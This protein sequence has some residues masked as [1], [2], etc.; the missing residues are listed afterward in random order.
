MASDSLKIELDV[1]T[2]QAVQGLAAV[3]R[4]L[5]SAED[6]AGEA[7]SAFGRFTAGMRAGSDTAERYYANVAR[8]A[9]VLAGLTRSVIDGTAAHERNERA[10]RTLG[11]AYSEV[12]RQTQGAF[13]AAEAMR[14]QQSLVQ[15]GLQLSGEELGRVTRAAREYALA[16]GTEATA[17]LE[18]LT[19]ALRGGE[20]EG[21][22]AFGITLDATTTRSQSFRAALTQLETQQ[23]G[24]APTAQTM[25]EANADLSRAWDRL[26]NSLASNVAQWTN[27]RERMSAVSELMGDLQENGLQNYLT[28]NTAAARDNRRSSE[29]A[30]ARLGRT[31]GWNNSLR[32]AIG[33]IGGEDLEFARASLDFPAARMTELTRRLDSATTIEELRAIAN[34]SRGARDTGTAA[35]VQAAANVAST[36]AMAQASR[37]KAN[38]RTNAPTAP[39]HGSAATHEPSKADLEAAFARQLVVA[40]EDATDAKDAAMAAFIRQQAEAMDTATE[41][42]RFSSQNTAAQNEMDLAAALAE[43][44][45]LKA[46]EQGV[47]DGNATARARRENPAVT[48]REAFLPA[49]METQTAAERMA[50]G[51][52]GA[53]Q[54][55]VGG[56]R[57]HIG[58]VIEGR[59][60]IGEAMR[61]I[62]HETLLALAQEAAAKSLMSLAGGI[63]ASV[64]PGGQG[65]AAGLFAASAIY[66]GVA[67]LAGL[68]A[69]ATGAP[70]AAASSAGAGRTPPAAASAGSSG[71][72]SSEGSTVVINVN[73][74]VMDR[75]G[76]ADSIRELLNDS[77]SRGGVLRAA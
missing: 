37:D 14:T 48:F 70:A 63:A 52:N 58:A 76:T 40:F 5:K 30:E 50:E 21:L 9:G 71:R 12:T 74:T 60:T 69:M 61:G 25:A 38:S 77:L 72:G 56:M 24:M 55:M 53:F 65:T 10:L 42:K 29:T 67:G 54:S 39:S 36:A 46:N 51:V 26:T 27:L 64:T 23:R 4:G 28:G 19:G 20:A 68:G 66:A 44:Q 33:R 47:Q 17:A 2:R 8:G 32:R 7:G 45:R 11:G 75:E 62:V 41:A 59:E 34:E 3:A 57:S 35:R 6:G 16:T 49:A 13:T 15:S 31:N 18:Q 22:R 43:S 1:E 73:G